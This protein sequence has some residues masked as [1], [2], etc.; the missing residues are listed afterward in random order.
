MIQIS[1]IRQFGAAL[2]MFMVRA[3]LVAVALFVT[4]RYCRADIVSLDFENLPDAYFFS[5]GG[6]NIGSYYSGVTFGPYVTGL[7]VS[8]FGGY[9]DTAYPPHS[10]DVVVWSAYD[11]TMTLDFSGLETEVSFW[12]TSQN[13]ITLAA[14]DSG[15][16]LLGSVLGTANTDGTTGFSSYLEFDGAGIESASITSAAG[17]YVIDDLSFGPNTPSTVPESNSTLL[18]AAMTFGMLGVA[19]KLSRRRPRWQ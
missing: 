8:R 4:A 19:W 1:R 14:Y 6:Q 3:A 11:D 7:S 9:S 17:Q 13:P 18:L 16:N 2:R 15:N 12:Y 10:G 5:A